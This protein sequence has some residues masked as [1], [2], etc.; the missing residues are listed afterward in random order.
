MAAAP[1]VA[2]LP[3]IARADDFE[4]P[5]S[6][7]PQ[8]VVDAKY[9]KGDYF[10]VIGD[11]VAQGDSNRSQLT[12]RYEDRDIITL[13]SLIKSEHEALALAYLETVK[14]TEAFVQGMV[15]ALKSPYKAVKSLV[16]DP[17]NTL[18]GVPEGIWKF[19]RRIGEM[20]TGSR[21]DDEDHVAE[22]LFGFSQI[23]R[24]IAFK[25]GV[26]VYSQNEML[27]RAM[28]DVAYAGFAGGFIF[29]KAMGGIPI[30]SMANQALSAV[31]FTRTTAQFL[32]DSAPEDLRIRNRRSLKEMGI[33]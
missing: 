32:R 23:K 6:F 16:T 19:G 17:V 9:L 11:V 25:L 7:A 18:M 4:G 29:S 14:N 31:E 15:R 24:K 28:N 2:A 1:G 27:Q 26:D 8:D 22:E 10:E 33:S 12:T 5:E 21:G 20:F 30:P 13:D 3:S